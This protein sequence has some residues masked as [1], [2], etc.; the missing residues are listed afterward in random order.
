MMKGPEHPDASLDDRIFQARSQL[1]RTPEW[2][3]EFERRM[4]RLIRLVDER[5]A[6][7]AAPRAPVPVGVWR[8]SRR[9][10]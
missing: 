8:C 4:L 9:C 6:R 2:H 3:P 1:Q 5:D 10:T 7:L